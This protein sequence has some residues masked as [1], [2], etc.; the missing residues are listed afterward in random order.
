MLLD[1]VSRRN[2]MQVHNQKHSTAI[3]ITRETALKARMGRIPSLRKPALQMKVPV[4]IRTPDTDFGAC[5]STRAPDLRGSACR[6]RLA[7]ALCWVRFRGAN[8][9]CL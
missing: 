8:Q 4:P 3:P 5:R 1:P 6:R 7:T 2:A 9:Y